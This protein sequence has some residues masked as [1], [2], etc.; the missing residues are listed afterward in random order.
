MQASYL[1]GKWYEAERNTDKFKGNQYTFGG[2]N[3]YH[4]Q[5]TADIIANQTGVT[6]NQVVKITT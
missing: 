2:G 6:E 3:F 4:H 1:R 5:K